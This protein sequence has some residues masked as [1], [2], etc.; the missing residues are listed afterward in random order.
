MEGSTQSWS[1]KSTKASTKGLYVEG[2]WRLALVGGKTGLCGNIIK[3]RGGGKKQ[4]TGILRRGYQIKS[5][6]NQNLRGERGSYMSRGSRKR[7]KGTIYKKVK[8]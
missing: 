5:Q 1:R 7:M 8:N 2:E 6:S 3:R 4:I